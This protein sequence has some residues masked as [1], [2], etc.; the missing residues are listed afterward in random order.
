MK[1]FKILSHLCVRKQ[2]KSIMCPTGQTS[3]CI[4][5]KSNEFSFPI[6]YGHIAG[7]KWGDPELPPVLCLHGWLD[8]CNSFDN[9][10]PLLSPNKYYVAID[11]PGHG[12]SSHLPNSSWYTSEQYLISIKHCFEHFKWKEASIIGHSMG[13]NVAGYF[14]TIFPELVINSVFID[15]IGTLLPSKNQ[16]RVKQIRNVVEASIKLMSEKSAH[17]KT[18]EFSE[19]KSKLLNKNKDLNDQAATILLQRGLKLEKDGKFS[20]RRDLKHLFSN[21]TVRTP[22]MCIENIKNISIDTLII[23]A[24]DGRM[25]NGNLQLYTEFKTALLS[26][27]NISIIPVPGKHHE[28]LCNPITIANIINNFF[29]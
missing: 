11:F 25:V 13:G 29:N 28:H 1:Q 12:F 2:I 6:S 5:T 8:N 22:S 20:F 3:R 9:L 27:K 14:S 15:A 10:I 16:D 23:Q 19:A 17:T 18:W 26:N 24:E 7:K 4:S 21:P